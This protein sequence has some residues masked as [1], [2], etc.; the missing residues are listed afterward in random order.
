MKSDGRGVQVI[1][2]LANRLS[3]HRVEQAIVQSDANNTLLMNCCVPEAF[4]AQDYPGFE[5]NSKV[6]FPVA[7]TSTGWP[8][9][10]GWPPSRPRPRSPSRR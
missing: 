1:G 5:G 8:G 7:A 6:I 10:P 9:W 4:M 3:L 2:G